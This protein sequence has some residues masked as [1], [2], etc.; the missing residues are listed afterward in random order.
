MIDGG[1]D[2]L[3]IPDKASRQLVR[4]NESDV[5]GAHHDLVDQIGTNIHGWAFIYS[6]CSHNSV[7]CHGNFIRYNESWLPRIEA[8]LGVRGKYL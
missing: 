1:I 3:V 8:T 2:S 5:A 6:L 7:P 4:V